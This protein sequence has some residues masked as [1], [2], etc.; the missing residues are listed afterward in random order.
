MRAILVTSMFAALC[1][2]GCVESFNRP[3]VSVGETT[4]TSSAIC[5]NGQVN[6]P[7]G[8]CVEQDSNDYALNDT[9]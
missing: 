9:P 4:T 6:G 8:Q 7:D 1:S 3:A 2:V 5:L